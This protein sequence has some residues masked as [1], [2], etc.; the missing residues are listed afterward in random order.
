[1]CIRDR[2]TGI[3]SIDEARI[4]TDPKKGDFY[5]VDIVKPGSKTTDILANALPQIIQSFPWPKSMRWGTGNLRWVRPIHSIIALFDGA[6][7]DF[8]IEGVKSG[9]SLIHI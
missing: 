6:V 1:M 5:V 3:N 7:V 2:K 4:E 9:L 8:E